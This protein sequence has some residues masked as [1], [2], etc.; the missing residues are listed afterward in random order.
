MKGHTGQ[1]G[2]DSCRLRSQPLFVAYWLTGLVLCILFLTFIIVYFFFFNSWPVWF[3]SSQAEQSLSG[4]WRESA[5]HTHSTKSLTL[6]LPLA[7]ETSCDV[8]AQRHNEQQPKMLLESRSLKGRSWWGIVVH[9]L[10]WLD[11]KLSW[12]L[13]CSSSPPQ[14][15]VCTQTDY[16]SNWLGLVW[17]VG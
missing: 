9:I 17:R 10:I 15:S 5:I 1:R 3:K 6:I 2:P 11:F 7:V 12:D 16:T 8:L 14:K 4:N 13:R